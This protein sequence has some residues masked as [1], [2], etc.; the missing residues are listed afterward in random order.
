MRYISHSP[1]QLQEMLKELGAKT[2]DELF[3]DIPHD[4]KLKHTLNLPEPMDE[5]GLIQD[6]QEMS[7]Q[8]RASEFINFMGAGAYDHHVPAVVKELVGRS[9][10]YTSYTPYQ[11]E[12]SQGMLAAIFEYQTMIANLTEMDVSNASVYDGASALAEAVL[13]ACDIKRKDSVAVSGGVHPEYI[14][15]VKTYCYGYGKK[16]NI[17]P[18]DVSGETDWKAA[19]KVI[20]DKTAAVIISVPNFFGVIEDVDNINKLS[21][22]KNIMLIS[23][24][25]PL[26]LG[27]IRSPG[28]YGADIAVGEGQPLGSPLNFGGPY[29][30]FMAAKAPYVRRLPGRVV[31]ETVDSQSKR[32]FVLTL[33]AREQHIRRE[34]ATSNICSNQALNALAAT[35][36]LSYLGKK[37]LKD[38][39]YRSHAGTRYFI[40][41]IKNSTNVRIVNDRVFNEVVVEVDELDKVYD[42]ALERGILPGVKLSRFFPK[43]D[44]RLLTAFTEKRTKPDIDALLDVLGVRS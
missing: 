37:G 24:V 6:F 23:V 44:K 19:E 16:V 8:N 13:M 25:N 39:A 14:E 32:A 28:S 33:Q 3:D 38:V 1:L 7:S 30:G 35:I 29:L 12:R 15:T 11:A 5:I 41:A 18:F 27:L 34:K 40:Q 9:E 31:G 21:E 10:F 36:Y 26:S 17:I 42:R 22:Q 20:D 2:I 4:V 43:Q